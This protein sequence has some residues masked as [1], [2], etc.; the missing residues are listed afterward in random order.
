M[1]MKNFGSKSLDEIKEKLVEYGH[2]I[3]SDMENE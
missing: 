2:N 3:S 1:R